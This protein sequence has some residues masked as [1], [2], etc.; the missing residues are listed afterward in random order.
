MDEGHIRTAGGE[1]TPFRRTTDYLM[2]ESC[3]VAIPAREEDRQDFRDFARLMAE[4][5]LEAEPGAAEAGPA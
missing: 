3:L 2:C 5:G 4:L 1:D